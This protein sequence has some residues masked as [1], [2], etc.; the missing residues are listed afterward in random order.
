MNFRRLRGQL[1]HFQRKS[2]RIVIFGSSGRIA[3]RQRTKQSLLRW[4][5]IL[6][7]FHEAKKERKAAKAAQVQ[8][9]QKRKKSEAEMNEV[10]DVKTKDVEVKLKTKSPKMK[11]Q[12]AKERKVNV[13]SNPSTKKSKSTEEVEGT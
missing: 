11:A 6:L 4:P 10:S 9:P 1:V 13:A 8:Q 3:R 5:P 2:R 12:K 7:S